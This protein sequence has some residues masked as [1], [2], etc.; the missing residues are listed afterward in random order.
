MERTKRVEDL[1][2]AASK[3]DLPTVQQL[4]CEGIDPNGRDHGGWFPLLAA[5]MVGR[6]AVVHA[7]LAAGADVDAQGP[8]GSTALMKATLWRQPDIVRV[9]LARGANAH[10]TDNRGWTPLDLALSLGHREL[11]ELLEQRI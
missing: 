6:P 10:I 1:I 4:L 8:D 11:V 7:L 9:L 3:A 5:V 2:D